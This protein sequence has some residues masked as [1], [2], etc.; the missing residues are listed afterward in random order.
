MARPCNQ[1]NMRLFIRALESGAYEQGT[2][3]LSRDGKLCCL[4]V[5]CETARKN[6]VELTM[7]E[8]RAEC[9][10][11]LNHT[12]DGPAVTYD[13][14]SGYL[15]YA[16]ADWLG[17]EDETLAS[18]IF[19]PCVNPSLAGLKAPEWNDSLKAPFPAIAQ[20]FRNEF[21]SARG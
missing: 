11:G 19:S 6:G 5:A 20:L 14:E 17:L 21:L 7:A 2:G 15:P 4:G 10:C 16:V 8:F 13:G 1:E 12:P 9:A 18:G 3:A